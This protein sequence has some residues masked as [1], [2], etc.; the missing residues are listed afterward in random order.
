MADVC[1]LGHIRNGIDC[2]HSLPEDLLESEHVGA[3]YQWNNHTT[4]NYSAGDSR[5]Q[6]GRLVISW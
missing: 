1:R 2:L 4:N 5:N 3:S 6:D